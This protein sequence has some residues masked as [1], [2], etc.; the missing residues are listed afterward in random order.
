VTE[1]QAGNVDFRPL[2]PRIFERIIGWP[3]PREPRES[4]T[5]AISTRHGRRSL[6]LWHGWAKRRINRTSGGG[7]QAQSFDGRPDG[8]FLSIIAQ[9]LRWPFC[10]IK[11]TRS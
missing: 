5:T 9:S 1:M 3:W 2:R 6:A 7:R 10:S 8:S 11:T 4:C